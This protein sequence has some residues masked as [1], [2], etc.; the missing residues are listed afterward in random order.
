MR[1]AA[2]GHENEQMDTAFGE[3]RAFT[4]VPWPTR[5]SPDNRAY[6]PQGARDREVVGVSE[7]SDAERALRQ[8]R[9]LT[10]NLRTVLDRPVDLAVGKRVVKGPEGRRLG[11]ELAANRTRLQNA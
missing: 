8:V 4:P 5:V 3:V 10:R 6:H 2:A 7:L 1:P 9:E 11:E